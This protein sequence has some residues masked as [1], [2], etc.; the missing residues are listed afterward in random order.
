MS[1]ASNTVGA[2]SPSAPSDES[3]ALLRGFGPVGVLVFMAILASTLLYVPLVAV[4]ILTW[5]RVSGTPWRS[6]G[7]SAP[8]S[9]GRTIAMGIVIGVVF[10]LLLKAVVMPL[11]GAPA[12]NTH[13]SYLTHNPAAVPGVLFAIIVGAGFGEETLFR[14][15]LFERFGKLFGESRAAMVITI[16]LT[17]IL[18]GLAHFPDQRIAGVEQAA[19]TG[20]LFGT[21]Y[22]RTRQLWI[23]MIAHAAFDLVA[24]ALI[25]WELES[26]VAK[27]LIR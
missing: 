23:P 4:L 1:G 11:L 8:R 20:L 22:A 12:I 15:Y 25:Y 18:F 24:V 3:A 13:Y 19:L 27:L 7:F 2:P 6:L 26:R 14:G 5:A 16:V 10:K 21:I 17:S 9:W